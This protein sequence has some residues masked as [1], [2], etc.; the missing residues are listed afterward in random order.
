MSD[1]ININTLMWECD[2]P[3]CEDNISL[4]DGHDIAT[5]DKENH[6]RLWED[7][8]RWSDKEPQSLF[9]RVMVTLYEHDEATLHVECARDIGVLPPTE[10]HA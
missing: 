3:S 2:H 7:G 9:K 4:S 8:E 1:D 5:L 10:D 6:P